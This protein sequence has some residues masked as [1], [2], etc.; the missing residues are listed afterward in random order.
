MHVHVIVPSDFDMWMFMAATVEQLK[1]F[2]VAGSKNLAVKRFRFF[3]EGQFSNM[4][5]STLLSGLRL[6]K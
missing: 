1:L 2:G 3:T 6:S 5:A 4:E